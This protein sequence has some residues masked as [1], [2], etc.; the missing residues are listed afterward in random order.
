MGSGWCLSEHLVE[1][2]SPIGSPQQA[3]KGARVP[4]DDQL[5]K[6]PGDSVDGSCVCHACADPG[7]AGSG[8]PRWGAAPQDW[9]A[10]STQALL[11]ARAWGARDVDVQAG[12]SST[13]VL[14]ASLP[15]PSFP[16]G[17]ASSPHFLLFSKKRSVIVPPSAVRSA[18]RWPRDG[19]GLPSPPQPSGSLVLIFFCPWAHSLRSSTCVCART[20]R[21]LPFPA[22]HMTLLPST[23]P[24]SCHLCLLVTHP[25]GL[26]ESV[27]LILLGAICS[28]TGR[29][30][31]DHMA[32][33]PTQFLCS[34]HF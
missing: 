19:R 29:C 24:G 18:W 16:Q 4:S 12:V 13:G 28:E 5:T 31:P 21:S 22:S 7:L 33:Q 3:G 27:T 1:G 11:G 34:V 26:V 14:W 25:P 20:G 23:A 30:P 2:R 8:A 17:R 9:W 32:V 15:T 10:Q 6:T